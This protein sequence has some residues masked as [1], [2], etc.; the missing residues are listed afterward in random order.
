MNA[1]LSTSNRLLSG[2]P[3]TCFFLFFC[4]LPFSLSAQSFTAEALGFNVFV[5]QD[6]VFGGGDVEGAV[7]VGNSLTLQGKQ[8]QFSVHSPGSYVPG[9]FAAPVG[10][11]VG[12]EAILNGGGVRPL[13]QAKVIIGSH[14]HTDALSLENGHPANTRI[15]NAGSTYSSNPNISLD[16]SQVESVYQNCPLDFAAAF[17]AFKNRSASV[18]NLATSMSI[19]KANGNPLN[20]ASLPT[21]SQVYIQHLGAGVNVL[22]LTGANLNQITSITF[23]DKP[24]A[25]KFL[26]INIDHT[27]TLNWG[28][29]TECIGLLI[30]QY[31]RS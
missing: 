6:F 5:E 28:S 20:P 19:T 23:N 30:C 29:S 27:G 14:S 16:H 7:A 10:L 13:N 4:L 15:V 17:T 12:N 11:V 22:N 3:L 31:Q 18:G 26:I 8:G 1:L 9:G 25:N 21:N 24:S 2:P